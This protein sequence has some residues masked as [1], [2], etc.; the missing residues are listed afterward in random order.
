MGVGPGMPV[1]TTGA[2]PTGLSFA[3]PALASA[4]RTANL[5]EITLTAAPATI[6]LGN[7]I[8]PEFW[9]FNGSIP[10]PTID[11]NEGDRVRIL[12]R[13]RLPQDSTVHWHGLPV[14]AAQDGN[15]MDP[16]A[17]GT[18]RL[19]EF[20]LP[21]GSAGTYWYH[22]HPHRTTHEQVYRGLAGLFIVRDPRDPLALAGV[23]EV[24]LVV[25]D[26]RLDGQ[27]RIAPNTIMDDINGR[28]GDTL[29]VN[30]RRAPRLAIR[31]GEAQRWRVLNAT[32]AR[33]LD[34][35]LG[36]RAFAV[37]ASDGGLLAA[38][39]E[40]VTRLLLAP[41]ER[42]ELVV[43]GS[44][45][46]GSVT[47]LETFAYGHGMMMGGFGSPAQV[48]LTLET[49][50]GAA[51]AFAMPAALRPIAALPEASA[52]RR[53]VLSGDGM[54][55]AFA[56]DGRAFEMGRVDAVS[57]RGEVERWEVVNASFMDHPFHVHG[58]QFQ[59]VSRTSGGRATP[60]PRLAWKDTVNVL[61]GETVAFL[62]RQDEAGLRMYH[63][64]IL[65]HED[66]GMM[67]VLAVT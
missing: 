47:T 38:P 45:A 41:A 60:E 7:N 36:G 53:I 56:I 9:A 10:G 12:F 66:A 2:I 8:A 57:R 23:P 16:V 18:D 22:P 62:V 1:G 17:P 61:P 39:V 42:A 31:A 29:L 37:V 13:N 48:L 19:Y 44:G 20:S 65:E 6:A 64:H 25:T 32:N 3:P 59:V 51:A 28:I 54:M 63:C 11:V 5:V 52:A 34:L 24:P 21:A 49:A 55:S 26:L 40:G 35:S 67:G 4:Q 14:P 50:A 15:P 43:V 33:Y 58:T 30:G 46:P 27:G